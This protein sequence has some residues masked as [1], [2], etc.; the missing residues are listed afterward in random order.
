ME[1]KDRAE[2]AHRLARDAAQHAYRL[3][4]A[5]WKMIFPLWTAFGA[6]SGFVLQSDKW[7]PSVF[8]CVLS[9]LV[10]SGI[11]VF[12]IMWS[13][14]IRKHNG[15]FSAKRAF[16]DSVVYKLIDIKLPESLLANKKVILFEQG[17]VTEYRPTPWYKWI[18]SI[19]RMFV[20]LLFA[21]LFL[22]SVIGKHFSLH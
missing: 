21:L 20:T 8:D 14:W 18:P 19:S 11:I 13:V 15:I 10:T 3:V 9:T 7:I 22:G 6:A 17:D 5:E 1:D 4:D 12:Y 16:W 2:F